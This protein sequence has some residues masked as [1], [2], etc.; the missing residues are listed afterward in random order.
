MSGI[1]FVCA[2][3]A[4]AAPVPPVP[5]NLA[6]PPRLVKPDLSLI[7][8]ACPEDSPNASVRR[9]GFRNGKP[10]PAE[11]VWETKRPNLRTNIGEL[12]I[13]QNRY[14]VTPDAVVIDLRD[15]NVVNKETGWVEGIDETKLTY[16]AGS[17]EDD[18][19]LLTF[20]Y[21]TGKRTRIGKVPT[22]KGFDVPSCTQI[23]RS[24]TSANFSKV[25]V[26]KDRDELIL[27]HNKFL[28][29][30]PKS[31]GKGFTLQT[32]PDV[33]IGAIDCGRF[34]VLWLDN[35]RFLTQRAN[36]KL[37][38]VDLAGKVTEVATIKD[39][40]KVEYCWFF[41]DVAG[42]IVYVADK[43]YYRIDLATKSGEKSEWMD[44]GNGFESS[45]EPDKEDRYKL[46]YQG[47][48]IGPFQCL[49]GT[50]KTAPGYIA[51]GFG[52]NPGRPD[53]VSVW[54]AATREWT[55]LDYDPLDSGSIVGWIK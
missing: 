12:R 53:R 39:V 19:D 25:I 13:V 36:G 41:R 52:T 28:K 35:E 44:L 21:A 7:V 31:L 16:S 2:I 15:N 10:M 1:A 9:V 20:E 46:R 38:T 37:V 8:V 23:S 22:R 3:L 49:P 30:E 14:L 54:F 17:D 42:G 27:Y 6:P 29:A 33:E 45:Y 18:C 51:L 43:Q 47:K 26:W 48:E 40:P 4:T 32:K 50:A 24:R 55:S 34:P 5:A 11:L